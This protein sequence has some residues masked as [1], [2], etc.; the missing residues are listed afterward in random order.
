[1][2]DH[3]KVKGKV[4]FETALNLLWLLLGL[5]ALLATLRTKQKRVGLRIMGVALVIAALF[6]FISASD[7]VLRIE[8]ATQHRSANDHLVRLYMNM[9]TPLAASTPQLSFTLCFLLLIAPLLGKSAERS[10]P[11]SI[12]RSPPDFGSA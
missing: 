12:G 6:P 2:G 11:F 1:M 8:Q 7:D 9:E 3:A 10:A 4:R 5:L